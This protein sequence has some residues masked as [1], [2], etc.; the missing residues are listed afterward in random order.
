[1]KASF[2]PDRAP[3]DDR[4]PVGLRARPGQRQH[5]ADRQRGPELRAAGRRGSPRVARVGD[6]RGDELGAV[7]DRSAA[8]R[9][10][11][12]DLLR[13]DDLDRP[14]QGVV[15]GVRLDPEEL[16]QRPA[17]RAPARPGRGRRSTLM[18][19][20]P[21]RRRTLAVGR[22]LLVDGGDLASAELDAGGIEIR[23]IF[24]GGCRRICGKMG[25]SQLPLCPRTPSAIFDRYDQARRRPRR[26]SGSVGCGSPTRTRWAGSPSGCSSGAGSSP[27]TTGWRMKQ[28]GERDARSSNSSRT[29]TINAQ[30]FAKSPFDFKTFNEFFHRALK[31]EA[32]PSRQGPALRCLPADGR[33]LAFLD[34]DRAQGFYVKGAKFTLEE[35]LGDE[36][37]VARFAGGSMLISR[38]C[39]ERL[40]PLSFSGGSG[41]PSEAA[42]GPG[43][44]LFGQPDR[45]A[46]QHQLPRAQQAVCDAS[47]LAAIRDGGDDRGGGDQ[48]GEHR[49]GLQSR[50][51]R[52]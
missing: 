47:R 20:P 40:P 17:C 30:E 27:G 41:I 12:V 4:G 28:A 1:M 13:A 45:A 44:P 50:A 11:P 46:A 16:E 31:P 33:H 42:A 51:G 3:A 29:M 36:A 9:E 22:K 6:G 34:V 2:S 18:L 23:E 48:R 15:V 43:Q 14:H 38:L 24:H 32:G 5:G 7:E 35:L 25:N 8:D 39:P 49:R 37:L 10:D 21:A 19:P 52:S 26:S